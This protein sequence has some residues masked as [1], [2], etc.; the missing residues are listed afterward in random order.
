[1]SALH[2]LPWPRRTERLLLRPPVLTDAPAVLSYRSRP[3][4]HRWLGRSVLTMEEAEACVADPERAAS[5]LIVEL[6]GVVIGDLMLM[7]KDGWAQQQARE[8]AAG[9]LN[10]LG[11][12]LDP[13]Y[14]GRGLATEA[15]AALLP[16]AFDEL[17][18][19]RAVAECFLLNEPSWRLMQRLGMRR[20]AHA[21][22]DSLH[23]ELGWL[24]GL[25]Y[26]LLASEWRGLTA[27]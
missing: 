8:Q 18:V 2:D 22:Q 5:L 25:T 9:Q 20:E 11:W 7:V 13:A 23:A 15:A 19:H 21:V 16:I 24:D 14:G 17:G 10:V 4:V 6:D 3:E 26:A 27:P 12:A 1:M